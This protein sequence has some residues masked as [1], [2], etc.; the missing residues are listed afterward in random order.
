MSKPEKPQPE[1]NI[2]Q[3]VGERLIRGEV[4]LGKFLGLTHEQLMSIARSGHKMLEAGKAP[5]ALEIFQGLVAAAPQDTVFLTQ[6][7]AT[8]MT[9]ERMDDAF[10]AYSQAIL[11]NSANVDALVGRGEIHL[12]RGQVPE[13]LKDLSRAI[14][15]DPGLKRRSTQRARGTL[16]ALKKQAEQAKVA[17]AA[18]KK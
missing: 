11:L 13:G 15:F 5:L 18:P 7:G 8:Y 10:D 4:S 2:P 6:L 3:D 12:R 14:E 16:L 1:I 17:S 9:L